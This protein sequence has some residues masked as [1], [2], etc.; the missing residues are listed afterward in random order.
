ME[1][2]LPGVHVS[3]CFAS[4][5]APS[6]VENRHCIPGVVSSCSPDYDG[7]SLAEECLFGDYSHVVLMN[8]GT[9]YFRNPHCAL[10]NGIRLEDIF[11]IENNT[12]YYSNWAPGTSFRCLVDINRGS[13]SC[14]NAELQTNCKDTEIYDSG[15]HICRDILPLFGVECEHGVCRTIQ[16]QNVSVSWLPV[17][18]DVVENCTLSKLEPDEF[19]FTD[20]ETLVE[21]AT[22]IEYYKLR[23][24]EAPT[25]LNEFIISGNN[26][27]VC[28]NN[29]ELCFENCGVNTIGLIRTEG[30]LSIIGL[31]ISIFALAITM[32]IYISLKKQ[33]NISGKNSLCLMTTLMTGQLSFLISPYLRPFE[34][35][36]QMIAVFTHLSFLSAFCWTNVMGFDFLKTFSRPTRVSVT[37]QT[38]TNIVCYAIYGFG[39]PALIVSIA[40]TVQYGISSPVTDSFKPNYGQNICW[41]NSKK[42]LTV[43]FF[44]PVACATLFDVFAFVI[45]SVYIARANR[46][47]ATATN[48]RKRCTTIINLKLAFIMGIPW[49]LALVANMTSN[50]SAADILWILFIV[51]NTLQGLVIAISFLCTRKM[52]R[53]VKEGFET[54]FTINQSTTQT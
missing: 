14:T 24:G 53:L 52:L 40:V 37:S 33:R 1:C 22:G 20:N 44:S 16:K 46:V 29:S 12:D 23:E 34:V 9:T 26:V 10:C 50:P 30:I 3:D 54:K 2:D 51:F 41:I 4:Y 47:G 21:K 18:F 19:L 8:S 38:P 43:F 36:C 5:E 49:V 6:G 25:C 7:S 27:F 17:G 48:R 42:G 45:K 35:G 39:V 11:C 13:V 28:V 31:S 32:I 15:S